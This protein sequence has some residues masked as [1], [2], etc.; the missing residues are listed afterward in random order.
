MCFWLR[1]LVRTPTMYFSDPESK[2]HAEQTMYTIRQGW[3]ALVQHS[4]LIWMPFD[5]SYILS[6][7]L[8]STTPSASIPDNYSS[9]L[10][11]CI[12]VPL[13]VS[14]NWPFLRAPGCRWWTTNCFVGRSR[15]RAR[16]TGQSKLSKT[17]KRLLLFSGYHGSVS[18]R[19]TVGRT[20]ST[21]MYPVAASD[22]R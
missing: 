13:F 2:F 11:S 17:W 22:L 6:L 1:K 10:T 15:V 4:G 12:P 14:V 7:V 21:N 16:P 19:T 8:S 20:K 3:Y 5:R 18:R 9:S